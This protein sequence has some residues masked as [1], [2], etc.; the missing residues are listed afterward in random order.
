VPID[1]LCDCGRKLRVK[2]EMAGKRV[3]CPGCSA[4]S[5]GEEEQ[6]PKRAASRLRLAEDENPRRP[7]RKGRGEEFVRFE[8]EGTLFP[9]ALKRTGGEF[10]VGMA[11]RSAITPDRG[12]IIGSD[13]VTS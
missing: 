8:G 7:A 10:L 4:A 1:L 9:F 13:G 5:D 6:A 3:K 11:V 12:N 2:D